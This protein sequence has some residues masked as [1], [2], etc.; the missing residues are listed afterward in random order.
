MAE[1]DM[2]TIKE[3]DAV[4]ISQHP[5]NSDTIFPLVVNEGEVGAEV[6]RTKK[7]S[8]PDLQSS[9][10]GSPWTDIT[11][12]L[13]TGSTT[14]TLTNSV[15]TTNSTIDVYT[16]VFGVNPTDISLSTGSITL[17]FPEQDADIGVKVRV[18]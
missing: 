1:S 9:I 7:I 14:L 15:L 10:T 13:T 18:T 17:T 2:K 3:L 5:L 6:W 8:F 16:S 12:T 11:G 4:D